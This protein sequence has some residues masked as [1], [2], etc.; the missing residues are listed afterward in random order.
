MHAGKEGLW[1]SCLRDFGCGV[2][3]LGGRRAVVCLDG[4][5]EGVLSVHS[6]HAASASIVASG[7]G[8]GGA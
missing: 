8:S 3:S 4:V 1:G 6:R 5:G 2:F 7:V